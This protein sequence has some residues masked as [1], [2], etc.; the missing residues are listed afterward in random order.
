MPTILTLHRSTV[1]AALAGAILIALGAAS[2]G[3]A[4]PAGGES[5]TGTAANLHHI[6]GFPVEI[7]ATPVVAQDPSL[8]LICRMITDGFQDAVA[9]PE[10]SAWLRQLV[11]VVVIEG[12]SA[13]K[14]TGHVELKKQVMTIRTLTGEAEINNLRLLVAEALKKAAHLKAKQG[15]K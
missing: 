13:G 12:W 8:P 14:Q 15:L 6:T 10:T 11:H 5:F 7:H 3:G 1:R 2:H 4:A 9:D